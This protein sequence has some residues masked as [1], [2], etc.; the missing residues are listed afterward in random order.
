MH[1]R[2][3]LKTGCALVALPSL[4]IAIPQSAPSLFMWHNGVDTV[5]CHT[6]EEARS[7]VCTQYYGKNWCRLPPGECDRLGDVFGISF[8]GKRNWPIHY[9]ELDGLDGWCRYDMDKEFTL[10]DEYPGNNEVTKPV[11]EWIAEHGKGYF[12]CS[13]Y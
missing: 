1:R 8:S 6:Q 5:I 3:F 10:W 12:A 11:R 7:L 4:P 2:E 13:E 9:D